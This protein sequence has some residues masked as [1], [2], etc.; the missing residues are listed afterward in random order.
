MIS[1]QYNNNNNNQ[2]N[3]I[4]KEEKEKCFFVK[5]IIRYTGN[6]K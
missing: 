5:I 3:Y 2:F 1:S 6:N 4:A